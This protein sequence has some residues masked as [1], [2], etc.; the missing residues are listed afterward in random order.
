MNEGPLQ[1]VR[2][3]EFTSAWAGPYATSILGF[4]G[5]EIIKVESGKRL[6]MTRLSAFSTGSTVSDPNKSSIFNNINLNK[7]S[8]TLNL[9]KPRAIEIAKQLVG[10]SSIT[11][12]NMRPGVMPRLGLSYEA[13]SA[14][15][16]DIIYL[17]SSACGQTGPDRE[18]VGYA[19]NFAAIGGMS[20]NT[21]YEDWGPSNLMGQIDLKS[22]STAAFAIL[23]ALI[24]HQK[25]GEGQY[26]DMASQETVAILNSDFLLDYIMNHREQKRRGNGDDIMAPHNCYPCSG[27]DKWISIVVA[28]DEEWQA[29]CTV[30]EKPDLV[31]DDRFSDVYNRWKNQ[32]EL[33]RIIGDWTKELDAYNVMEKLQ[34]AG[35]AAAPSLSSEGLF[36]DPHLKERGVFQQIDHPVIGKDWVIAPP[37]RLSVT[38]ASIRRHAPL[39]GEHN[40]RVFGQLLGM[41]REE[42]VKLE[43]EEVIF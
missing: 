21:G 8:V 13:L 41:S 20:Y 32:A 17:S 22:A 4:L 5:A 19:P 33:D 23:M 35:V 1:G 29:L 43:E 31:G 27:V 24:H 2:V 28:D 39:F 37:W 14:V 16:S 3:T 25:T 10:K 15:K 42:I 6:D 40:D 30:M 12:E 38:P 36:N 11:V 18:F 9:S 26:I 34:A 7:Q